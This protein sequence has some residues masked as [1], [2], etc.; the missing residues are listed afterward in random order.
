MPCWSLWRPRPRAWRRRRRP[1]APRCCRVSGSGSPPSIAGCSR[2]PCRNRN[3]ELRNHL[4]EFH[5]KLA[6]PAACLVFT[7]FALPAGFL[8]PRSGRAY[9]LLV[10]MIMAALYWS[11]LVSAHSGGLR[12]Q[13]APALAIWAPNLVV[14]ALSGV[15]YGLWRWRCGSSA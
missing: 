12:H 11:L 15:L 4:F 14:L 7:L 2:H 13:F 6:V 5:K 8:A 10:G 3:R 9:G 1:R